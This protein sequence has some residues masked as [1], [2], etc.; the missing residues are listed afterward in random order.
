MMSGGDPDQLPLGRSLEHLVR[1]VDT[2]NSKKELPFL[3]SRC[4]YACDDRIR[5]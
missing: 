3:Q 4:G 1:S 2:D 5:S